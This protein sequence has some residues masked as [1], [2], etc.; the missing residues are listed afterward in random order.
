MS[1]LVKNP[2]L[3]P[4]QIILI[5]VSED[6]QHTTLRGLFVLEDSVSIGPYKGNYQKSLK[7]IAIISIQS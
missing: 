4:S 1:K 6:Q 5:R 2:S 7:Q 3:T